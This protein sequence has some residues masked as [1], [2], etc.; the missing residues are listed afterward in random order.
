MF[1]LEATFTTTAKI[2]V[3]NVKGLLKKNKFI[4]Y[5]NCVVGYSEDTFNLMYKKLRSARNIGA[6]NGSDLALSKRTNHE[7]EN[8]FKNCLEFLDLIGDFETANRMEIAFKSL[9]PQITVPDA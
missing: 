6:H 5:I 4:N 8:A 3:K 1:Q 7:Y 9:F 2:Y